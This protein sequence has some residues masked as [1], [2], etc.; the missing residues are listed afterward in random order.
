MCTLTGTW[1]GWALSRPSPNS[2]AVPLSS[3][4]EWQPKPTN[5]QEAEGQPET[6]GPACRLGILGFLAR[7]A[8][9]P[10]PPLT[11]SR[12]PQGLQVGPCSSWGTPKGYPRQEV[13]VGTATSTGGGP[14]RDS[15]RKEP[16]KC[17]RNRRQD[18]SYAAQNRLQGVELGD[19][20]KR[21]IAAP[22]C[23]SANKPKQ[24]LP[25]AAA[26]CDRLLQRLRGMCGSTPSF[27]EGRGGRHLK[28]LPMMGC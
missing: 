19:V 18:E 6:E 25:E 11:V 20:L 28:R 17:Y 27:L 15:L 14:R 24:Q 22:G 12:H 26:S 4:S 21:E 3:W 8:S 13:Q 5:E 23:R 16:A 7:T 9:S 10:P 2:L 1:E